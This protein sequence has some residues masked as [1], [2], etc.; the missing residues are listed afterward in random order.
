MLRAPYGYHYVDT[1]QSN[2]Q[3]RCEVHLEQAQ[4]V[5]QIFD[6]VGRERVSIGQVCRRLHQA[7]IPSPKG[8]PGGER[9]T[10]SPTACSSW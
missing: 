10:K 7:A 9:L 5:R 4:V 2:G 8:K 6:W 3:A 1:Q